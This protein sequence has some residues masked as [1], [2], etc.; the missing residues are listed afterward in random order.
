MCI[1]DRYKKVD[2]NALI[3]IYVTGKD[4]ADISGSN[5]YAWTDGGA[6]TAAWPGT[7]LTDV[8]SVNGT[9]FYYMSFDAASVNVIFNR[10]GNQTGDITGLTEDSY[11]EYD[12]A[13]AA[14]KLDV[15]VPK[16]PSVRA[17]PASGTKF[18][19]SLVV[20]LTAV[21]A[22]EIRYTLDGST[23]TAASTLY[24]APIVLTETTDIKTFVQ[25]D[26]GSNVQT[27][28]YTKSDTPIQQGYNIYFD[29]SASNWSQVYCYV[30]GGTAGNDFIGGWP[31]KAMTYDAT[32]GY[33]HY[34]IDTDK[35]ITD[36]CIIFS[37]NGN[38]QTADGVYVVNN[39]IYNAS[40]YTGQ[41]Y[42]SGIDAVT[43][44]DD[45]APVY[46]NLQGIRVD[47]PAHGIY[48]VR[49]GSKVSTVYI[50]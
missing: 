22:T 35:D 47:N 42:S 38:P 31:G 10:G 11:F 27:F 2:P 34:F 5:V 16:K 33:W 28:S 50:R 39:G 26:E 13:K 45:C 36:S 37:N 43:A 6:L 46:Y 3:T 17:N 8:T 18:N 48:I 44:D 23:P 25:N 14:T 1:R 30:Y 4:G 49:R 40:G 20:T 15:T 19:E 12:G 24:T 32:S 9:D 7:A 41:T 29:N 21:N